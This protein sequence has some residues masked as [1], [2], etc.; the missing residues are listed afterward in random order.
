[1]GQLRAQQIAPKHRSSVGELGHVLGEQRVAPA[2][3]KTPLVAGRGGELDVGLLQEAEERRSFAADPPSH[4]GD[5][6]F[7]QHVKRGLAIG[8]AMLEAIL[9]QREIDQ[10][11]LMSSL[12]LR[13]CVEGP[14]D[15]VLEPD[16]AVAL[17]GVVLQNSKR[18]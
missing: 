14:M 2:V 16:L 7:C 4:T 18:R 3:V 6:V 10:E 13:Q 17:A 11:A 8:P 9:R 15:L 5:V 12:L 1:M